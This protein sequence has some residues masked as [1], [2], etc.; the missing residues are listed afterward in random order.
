MRFSSRWRNTGS[1]P[2]FRWATTA[3]ASPRRRNTASI[4]HDGRLTL[5]YTLP[6]AAAA[7]HQEPGA[8]AGLRPGILHRLRPAERRGG[9]ARRC[10]AGC[11]LD[12]Y[13][14][15][16]PDAA[17]AAALATIG[18]DQREMPADMQGLTGGIDNSA[19]I[20]CGGPTVG[21]AA[22]AQPAPRNAGEAAQVMAGT[23][24][25][26]RRPHGAARSAHGTGSGRTRCGSASRGAGRRTGASRCPRAGCIGRSGGAGGPATRPASWRG[27]GPCRRRSIA[28]SPPR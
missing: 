26:G 4:S 9:A 7:A 25:G 6:L 2:S 22:G 8:R 19:E 17:A 15:Q 14:A 3:P 27:S 10:P 12:V 16:G 20:N 5:H 23:W 24:A 11:R 28:S 1:S 18:P 21:A 13:P